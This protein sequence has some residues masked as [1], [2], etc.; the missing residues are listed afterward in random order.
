MSV[1]SHCSLLLLCLGIP[2]HIV[3]HS[4]HVVLSIAQKGDEVKC[5]WLIFSFNYSTYMYIKMVSSRVFDTMGGVWNW[6]DLEYSYI[7]QKNR[8]NWLFYWL[9]YPAFKSNCN[10]QNL[11]CAQSIHIWISRLFLS[12]S[13]WPT[14]FSCKIS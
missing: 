10:Q 1:L 3:P 14:I 11:Y 5:S 8:T 4:L 2:Y 13:T 7:P 9:I 12:K 6:D